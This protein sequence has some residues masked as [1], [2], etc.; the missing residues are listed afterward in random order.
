MFF[1]IN[2]WTDGSELVVVRLLVF[3]HKSGLWHHTLSYA[4][5]KTVKHQM[6]YCLGT[7]PRLSLM[8]WRPGLVIK[9]SCL[10]LFRDPRS[11]PVT[12]V[13]WLTTVYNSSSRRPLRAPELMCIFP[14]A[15]TRAHTQTHT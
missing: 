1:C 14:H 10:L 7:D 3:E 12:H 5:C 15:H 4:L 9:S 2:T 8:G 11:V 6:P 13:R